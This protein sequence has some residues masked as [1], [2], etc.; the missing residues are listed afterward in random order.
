VALAD[1]TA[2]QSIHL[3]GSNSHSWKLGY[4]K[5][6]DKSET[7]FSPECLSKGLVADS[8]PQD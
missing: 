6:L 8:T 2:S 7:A 1:C 5:F 4:A 3:A